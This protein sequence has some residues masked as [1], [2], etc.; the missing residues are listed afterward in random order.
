MKRSNQA[1]LRGKFFSAVLTVILFI[2]CS[3]SWAQNAREVTGSVKDSKGIPLNGASLVIKGTTVGT[4]TNADGK[5]SLSLSGSGVILVISYAGYQNKEIAIKNLST[6]DVVLTESNANLN[7]VVVTGYSK[8]SKRDVTGAVS[9]ISATTIAQTPVTDI[10]GEL[11]GRVSGVSV[12]GQGGP[13]SSQIIRIRGVGTLGDNDPLYVIDGVQIR[14]GTASN[15]Q[16]IS[17]LI[18]PNDIESLTILKDPSLIALYG[19]EGANG[20]IVITTKTGKLGAPKLEYNAYAGEEIPKNLPKFIT[21]AQQANALY[22]SFSINNIPIPAS[23]SSIYGSGSAPVL[24]DYIIFEGATAIGVPAGDPRVNPSLYNL[25][26]YRIVQT[27]KAGTNW[28]KALFKPASTQNHQLMLSGANDKSNYAI[29]L[30][31]LDD[32]GTE[33]NSYFK[34]LSLRVNTLFKIKPWLRI[35]ENTELSYATAN[36]GEQ[37]TYNTFNNDIGAIYS[38]S[39]LLSTH[40]IAGN[41]TGTKG[42]TI[43]GGGNPLISRTNS[44]GSK[45]YGQSIIGAAFAEIEPIKGLIYTNQIGFQFLPS[46]YHYFTPGDFQDPLGDTINT[47]GEGGAYSTD[48]RWLNKVSYSTTI[49]SIHSITAFVGY[50][51]HA[52]AYRSYGGTTGN[53]AFPSTNN[54]YLSSGNSGTDPYYTP[55]VLGGGDKYTSTAVLANITYSLMD[56]YLFTATGRRDGSSKFGPDNPFGN[57]GSVSAGWRISKEAFMDKVTWLTDLKLRGAY[58]TIGNDAIGTGIYEDVYTSD[59]FGR[60]DLGGTNTSSMSGYYLYL[61]GNQ[62]IKWETNKTTNLGFDAT[63]FNRLTANFSWFNRASSGVLYAPP[64]SGT[65][66]SALSPTLNLMDITNNGVE[67]ELSYTGHVGAV[68]FDMGFNISS[69]QNKVTHIDNFGTPIEGGTVGSGGGTYLTRTVVGRPVSSFYGYVYQGLYRTEKDTTHADESFFGI[70]NANALGH[71]MYK[72]LNGDGVINDSDRT[73]LGNPNPKFSYGYDLRLSYKS[74]DF[75]VLLQGVYGNKIFDYGKVLTTMPNGAVTG[76]GGYQT[77]SLD[78]WSPSNPNASLPIYEQNSMA[79]DLSP[80]SFYIESGSYMRIKQLQLGYTFAKLKGISKLRVY[81]QAYN[82]LTITKYTGQDP[83][84]NDGDPHNLGID[85]G[86]AYPITKKFLLG[87]NLG[88]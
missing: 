66:G 61:L 16:D 25:N 65:Q 20:V 26:N 72:D 85:F 31:Y 22:N 23:V 58:G 57:F 39:P 73:F 52:F 30:G 8:Q 60:Y 78:T 56:K 1:N 51:A 24:P 29:T 21:P 88:L 64:S 76:Q 43:L 41:I 54:E 62:H 69:Y 80:S 55:A 42:S 34:R 74:F 10:T 84:V 6:V 79:N 63:L 12:D 37:R 27:N 15:S 81:V 45:S 4:E 14:M 18:N 48:W 71:V 59:A 68:K 35:G 67:L 36:M 44:L 50:E 3:F 82:L 46:E 38:L 19:A 83:E 7:E 75:E 2:Q 53:L 49:N 9:T 17:S 5:F 86:T 33:V 87:I 32:Q 77:G 40:D 70:T 47:F 13:G 28:F 11:Q